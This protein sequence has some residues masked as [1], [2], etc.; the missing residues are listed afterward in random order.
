M[1]DFSLS[2]EIKELRQRTTDFVEEHIYPN[3][4]ISHEGGREPAALTQQPHAKAKATGA[5]FETI[6]Q[7]G[8][9]HWT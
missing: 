6:R 3:E 2:P 4:T 1:V 9:V 7:S 8:T 5:R